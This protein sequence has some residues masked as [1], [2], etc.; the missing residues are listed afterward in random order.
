[1]SEDIREMIDKVKNVKQFVNEN[2]Q[3]IKDVPFLI[4]LLKSKDAYNILDNSKASDTTFQFG[5]CLILADALSIYYDLP[6]YVVYNKKKNIIEH[7]VVKLNSMFLDSD[8]IQS[9]I[10]IIKK[11]ADD[12]IYDIMDLDLIEYSKEMDSSD[13]IKDME[14]SKKLIELFNKT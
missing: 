11:V 14:A 4:K 5:G 1:M 2:K 8:G 12:G 7:F 6:I 9:K 3:K 10:E 13:I